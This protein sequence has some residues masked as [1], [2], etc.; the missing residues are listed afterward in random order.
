[1]ACGL[2]V[3]VRTFSKGL[4]PGVRTGWVQA[5]P[6]VI[7]PMATLKRLTDLETSPLLQAALV[8]ILARGALDRHLSALREELRVRHDRAQ[9]ALAANLPDDWSWSRP[10]G[11]FALWLEGPPA[12]DSERLADL[13][14]QRGVLVA[15]GRIFD[16]HGRPG[17]A[18]RLSLSRVTAA[19][20]A[21]GIEILG[22][23]A[24]EWL[25]HADPLQRTNFM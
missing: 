10:D 24:R 3:T 6:E 8:D 11:G 14:A 21:E 9:A 19:Q 4:F 22:S 23:C 16:P 25:V 18:L 7:G 17:P 1:V 12:C 2:T 20:V 15:P 5:S 13:A